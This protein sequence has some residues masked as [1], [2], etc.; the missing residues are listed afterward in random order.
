MND[1]TSGTSAALDYTVPE[2]L[3][4]ALNAGAPTGAGDG[5]AQPATS[6]ATGRPRRAGL[7]TVEP[8]VATS[9]GTP[10]SS[11]AGDDTPTGADA[12]SPSPTSSTSFDGP[13]KHSTEPWRTPTDVM[14]LVAQANALATE[15]LNGTVEITAV[16]AYADVTHV[17]SSLLRTEL[18]RRR[19]TGNPRLVFPGRGRE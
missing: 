6:A 4:P 17:I 15:V 5:P 13:V 2:A 1:A 14:E 7:R 10:T 11:D 18:E 9:A 19:F 12:A 8:F 16:R 3:S